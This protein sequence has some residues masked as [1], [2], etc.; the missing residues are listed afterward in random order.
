MVFLV[1]VYMALVYGESDHDRAKKSD[2][3]GSGRLRSVLFSFRRIS[4]FHVGLVFFL[5]ALL[6]WMVPEFLLNLVEISITSFREFKWLFLGLGLFLV[7]LFM[8]VTYLRYRL[9]KHTLDNQFNLEKYRL[10]HQIPGPKEA[11]LLPGQTEG[12]AKR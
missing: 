4:I 8:W 3:A 7:L 12:G 9:S 11:P 5:G 1:Q 2:L 6:F 10:Q